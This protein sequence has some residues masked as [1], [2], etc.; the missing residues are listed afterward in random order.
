MGWI[1]NVKTLDFNYDGFLTM[2][3]FQG[4]STL[5]QVMLRYELNKK[6]DGSDPVR[7]IAPAAFM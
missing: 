4:D 5:I 6:T 1:P 3:H 2:T 7:S